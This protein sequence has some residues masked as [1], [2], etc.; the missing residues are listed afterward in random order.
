MLVENRMLGMNM[1]GEDSDDESIDSTMSPPSL[2]EWELSKLREC[3]KEA[4]RMSWAEA[5]RLQ[6]E[7]AGYEER[8][9]EL[10]NHIKELQECMESSDNE[11]GPL[12]DHPEANDNCN[13]S[14]YDTST[15]GGCHSEDENSICISQNEKSDTPSNKALI[16]LERR[17][18]DSYLE[19][20]KQHTRISAID[21]MMNLTSSLKRLSMKPPDFLNDFDSDYGANGGTFDSADAHAQEDTESVLMDRLASLEQSMKTETEELEKQIAERERVISSLEETAKAQEDAVDNLRKKI[22]TMRDKTEKES[23]AIEND[24][25]MLVLH[26]KDLQVK[27]SEL[28]N[29]ILKLTKEIQEKCKPDDSNDDELAVLLNLERFTQLSN[30]RPSTPLKR[31]ADLPDDLSEITF[32]QSAFQ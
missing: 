28:D 21:G 10:Q 26:V 23:K 9:S 17:R 22:D 16:T 27:E 1:F 3:T 13:P 24:L 15:L 7:N 20:R 4:L 8:I 32:D 29:L 12:T 2:L 31:K 25:G 14:L 11:L 19:E 5:E 18:S 30:N 6:D